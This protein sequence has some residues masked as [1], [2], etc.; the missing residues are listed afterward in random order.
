M[1]RAGIWLYI[2]GALA[3]I[4]ILIAVLFQA[5][6]KKADSYSKRVTFIAA[7]ASEGHWG[8][9][10]NSL[11]M[12]GKK[13]E[14]SVK[15]L[16]QTDLALEKVVDNFEIAVNAESDGIISYGLSNSER[17]KECLENAG[18][19]GIPVILVDSDIDTEQK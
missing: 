4:M 5:Q 1:K 2:T 13:T 17:F 16:A 10:A 3:G 19:K 7:L 9:I 8:R 18:K 6:S 15:C 11:I 14:I 12:E